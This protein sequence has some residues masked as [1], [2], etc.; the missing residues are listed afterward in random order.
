MS[1]TKEYKEFIPSWFKIVIST[2]KEPHL[3][4]FLKVFNPREIILDSKENKEYPPFGYAVDY[5]I[6][7]YLNTT[8][9]L[10]FL[11]LLPGKNL[12]YITRL[13]TKLN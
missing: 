3:L 6:N 7:N 12:F 9:S 1:T 8:V 11:R 4:P 13:K 5:F 2:R 10:C